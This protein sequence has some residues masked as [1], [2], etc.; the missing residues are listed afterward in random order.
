MAQTQP[1]LVILPSSQSGRNLIADRQPSS[2]TTH[3]VD[4]AKVNEYLPQPFIDHPH[5]TTRAAADMR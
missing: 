2:Y 4:T 3:S 1:T 5:E